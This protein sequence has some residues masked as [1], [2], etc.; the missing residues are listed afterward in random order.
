MAKTLVLAGNSFIGRHIV[1]RLSQAGVE[2]TATSRRS[3]DL[4][5]PQEV[6]HTIVAT[7]PRWIIQCAGATTGG[8]RADMDRLHVDGTRSLLQAVARHVP[9]ATVVLFGSAAEYGNVP[10]A[11]LPTHEDYPP[12]PQSPFGQS[13]LAQTRLAEQ[14]AGEHG[15]RVLLLRPFNVLGPGLPEHY[16]AGTLARRLLNCAKIV[17]ISNGQATRDWVDVRDVA[18]AVTG[19]LRAKPASGRV[20]IYN[21]ATGIETS[22]LAVAQELCRLAG[23][24]VA[25]DGEEDRGRSGILLSCGDASRLR[26]SLGWQPRIRWQESLADLW[27]SLTRQRVSAPSSTG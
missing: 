3:C 12:D 2:V 23:D 15:L 22:V 25:V 11:A 9:D 8:T 27:Q 24:L 13:K 7:L 5:N 16:F 21:V 26:D 1:E 19:L 17:P 10:P 14:L 20:S 18:E 6:E 4:T